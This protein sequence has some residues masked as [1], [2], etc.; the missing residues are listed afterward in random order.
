MSRAV[1]SHQPVIKGMNI[2]RLSIMWLPDFK[3]VR[4]QNFHSFLLLAAKGDSRNKLGVTSD[5]LM[6]MIWI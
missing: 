1:S 2:K 4:H 3:P 6:H 5:Y